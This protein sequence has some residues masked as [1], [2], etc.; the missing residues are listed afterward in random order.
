M[1]TMKLGEV[2]ISRVIEIDRSSFPTASML[3]GSSAEVIAGHHRWLKPH[4]FD[5]TDGRSRRRAS[6]PTSCVRREHTILI[7]T[8]VGNGKSAPTNPV[9]N[10]RHGHPTSTISPPPASRRSS[11][12]YVR[13]HPLCTSTTWAGTRGSWT[14][15]GCPTFPNA[16]YVI[17]GRG[18]GVLAARARGRRGSR[19]ASPT[20]S[21]PVVEA[22]QARSRRQRLTRWAAHLTL[23][24]VRAA[25]RPVTSACASRTSAGERGLL[26][27]SHAPHRAG[28]RAPVERAASATTRAQAAATRGAPSSSATPIP[29][30]L[31]LAAH[32]PHPGRIVRDGDG[33]R[34]EPVMLDA[35]RGGEGA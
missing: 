34:F 6:R 22:G 23:R 19:A 35:Y 25:T 10:M 18:V 28:G 12:D 1:Q 3:P 17:A 4:F 14:G 8:G 16:R 31:I 26:R 29:A 33:H 27:R 15:A 5:E 32:F 24:A 11:V 7:D 20:A 2:T 13:L 21:L 30:Y 9:W